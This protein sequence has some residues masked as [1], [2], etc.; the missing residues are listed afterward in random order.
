MFLRIDYL[1][2]IVVLPVATNFSTTAVADGM[3]RRRFLATTAVL[4]GGTLAG[5]LGGDSDSAGTPTATPTPTPEWATENCQSSP[6][7]EG[8]P[9]P[10]ATRTSERVADYVTEFE[11]TYIV[12]T[13]DSYDDIESVSVTTTEETGDGY[14]V[15]LAVEGSAE[16]NGTETPQPA[17]ATSHRV[18][19]RLSGDHLLREHQGYAAGRTLSE[20]C[21][22]VG[23]D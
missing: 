23:T 2:T 12:A 3:N 6:D 19:Y 5:C 16:G 9:E 11:R 14:R 13:D 7:V 1:G 10:P 18:T 22:T 4:A 17:D 8:L 20:D 21:W 15:E